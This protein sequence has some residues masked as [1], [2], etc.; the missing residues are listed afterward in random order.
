MPE[1]SCLSVHIRHLVCSYLIG[2][3][4]VQVEAGP[5]SL[6]STGLPIKLNNTL[7]FAGNFR[8]RFGRQLD[9]C[10]PEVLIDVILYPFRKMFTRL[11]LLLCCLFDCGVQ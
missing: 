6:I 1:S 2:R 7:V 11:M 3:P 5:A 9:P 10:A 8:S 4:L